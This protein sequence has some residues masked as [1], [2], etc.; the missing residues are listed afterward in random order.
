MKKNFTQWIARIG[1]MVV[2]CLYLQPTFAQ[3]GKTISLEAA[4]N[5]VAK[6]YKAKFAYEHELIQGKNTTEGQLKAKGLE[7]VLKQILYPNKLLFLYV[8][9]RNYTIVSQ[10]RAGRQ[11]PANQVEQEQNPVTEEFFV[12]GRVEDEQGKSLPGATIKSDASNRAT[13]ADSNGDFSMMVPDIATYISISYIGYETATVTVKSGMKRISVSMKPSASSLLDEVNVVSNGYQ[14]LPRERST[15]SATLITSKDLEKIP[16]ANVIQRLESM[17]PGV[18]V[19]LNSGDNS[20]VYGNTQV[21]IGSGTRTV[22]QSDY[23]MS[24][25]GRSTVRGES[26][27]L[28]VVDGAIS[29]M[30]LSTLNPNDIAN[31]TFLKDAAAASIWGT[32]AANGVIVVTTKKGN[33]NQAPRISISA[34]T[35]ISNQPDLDYLRVMNSAQTIEYE[36]EMVNKGLITAPNATTRQGM[37]VSEV[38]DLTFRL[39]AGTLSQSEYDRIIAEYSSRDNRDQISQYFL[40]PSTNQQYNF[41]VNGGSTA[42]PIL[43]SIPRLIVRKI[44]LQKAPAGNA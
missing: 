41:S 40:R 21:A 6:Q 22:G 7:E 3:S 29:E 31:I 19:T 37:P 10:G 27:P 38:T 44:H 12:A 36:Q 1:I 18:K 28:V 11:T 35:G 30:D 15:G 5:T 34:T 16:V 8:S 25:R 9:E 32:R 33:L 42:R 20:F 26:F 23:S 4:L 13:N 2:F 14:T 39:R 43:I 17:I 24:I